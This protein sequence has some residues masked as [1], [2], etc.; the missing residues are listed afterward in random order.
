MQD[1]ITEDTLLPLLRTECLGRT[2]HAFGVCDSTITSARRLL[3]G[4]VEPPH[5][6]LVVADYQR[7]GYGRHA[8]AWQAPAGSALLFSVILYPDRWESG[9]A[10]AA[11]MAAAVAVVRALRDEGV[12]GCAIKWPN[13]VLSADGRKLCGILTEQTTRSGSDAEQSRV[14]ITGIGI[15][16]NQTEADFPEAIRETAGSIRMILGR[17]VL[18]AQL[19]AR[20][21]GEM[22]RWLAETHAVLFNAWQREC[23]TVG[24]TVRVRLADH[25]VVGQA[26]ALE[27]DGSLVLRHASGTMETVHS[28]DVEELR[29]VE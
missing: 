3:A 18:R 20:V 10:C 9:L 29:M 4:S 25:V 15:N 19:L 7:G 16:V 27:D 21:L 8:R 26:L 23:C 28:A 2:I 13:D 11:T 22:E 5:G 12:G 6:T 14:L 17:E 24:R 1:E